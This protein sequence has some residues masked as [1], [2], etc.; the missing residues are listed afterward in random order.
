MYAIKDRLQETTYSYAMLR[1]VHGLASG[2]RMGPEVRLKIKLSFTEKILKGIA[3]LSVSNLQVSVQ[4]IVLEQSITSEQKYI[5]P[6]FCF[7]N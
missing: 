4:L 3:F 6:L 5:A 1:E 7:H 2:C